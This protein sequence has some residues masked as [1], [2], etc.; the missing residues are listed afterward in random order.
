VEAIMMEYNEREMLGNSSSYSQ[1]FPVRSSRDLRLL[2]QLT[3]LLH[4]LLGDNLAFIDKFLNLW[5][6][7]HRVNHC[8]LIIW[9]GNVEIGVDFIDALQGG[10]EFFV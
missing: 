7:R 2:P 1:E 9:V 3:V 4:D 6:S 10:K 5:T 8:P